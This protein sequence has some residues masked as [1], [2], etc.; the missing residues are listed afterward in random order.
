MASPADP[1]PPVAI[2]GLGGR[3]PGEATDP[4]KLYDMCAAGADAWTEVP[5]SRF[6]HAAF[7]HPDQARNG[8]TNVTGGFYLRDDVAFF[9][10]PFFGITQTEAAS[11][12]P[13]QRLLLECSYEALENAGLAL[14]DVAGSDMGVFVG[15]FC[16]DWAKMTLRDP[17]AIPLYHATGTGQAMLANRLSYF[18]NLHGPSVTLD[19]ACSS[20]LVA[21]HQACQ[22]LRAGECSTALVAGVNCSLCHDSLAS[23]SSM[24]FLSA[25]GRSFTYDSRAAGYG[26]GEG[27]AALVLRRVEAAVAA[28][29]SVRA[30]V[31]N[32]GVN[33]DGRTPGITF[34]SGAAQAALI[35]R[36]YAQAGL[37]LADTS[38]VEAHGTG[39]QAGDPIE[40]RALAETFGAVRK[41]ADG[42]LVVGCIKTNI[43]H[44]EGAS[45]AAGLIKTVLM[46]ER[47]TLLPNC[48]FRE[49]NDKIPLADWHLTV[50]TRV[51]PWR[52]ALGTTTKTPAVL[53]ASIN[54]FGYGGTNAH[55]IVESAAD[56]L[57]AR[58]IDGG[59]YAFSHGRPATRHLP[60][61]IVHEHDRHSTLDVPSVAPSDAPDAPDAPS[62]SPS[63]SP[64]PSS[65]DSD[66]TP[67]TTNGA[68]SPT[69]ET[70]KPDDAAL[71]V[72]QLFVLSAH[73]ATAG[74]AQAAQLSDYLAS[75]A[76]PRLLSDLAYTLSTR[77]SAL[78]WK[79]AVAAASASQLA[80]ALRDS[81]LRFHHT[82]A[83]AP[84]RVGFVFT[85]QGAQ[86][87]A[88]GRELAAT[89]AVFRASLDRSAAI[90][91]SSTM[92]ADW[93]LHDEL[94]R[95]DA[96]TTRVNE[97]AVSQPLCTVLQVA[98]VDLLR[99]WGVAPAAVVGHSSGEIGAAYAAGLLSQEA[100][101]AAAYFRVPLDSAAADACRGGMVALACD[102]ATTRGL[103]AGLRRGTAVIACYNS[104][105]SFTVSGDDAAIEELAAACTAAGVRHRTLVVGFAYHSH[106]MA[107]AAE[108]YRALLQ[109]NETVVGAFADP[110]TTTDSERAVEM[111][112]SVTGRKLQPGA[113]TLDYWVENLV[114]PVRFTEALTALCY[115]AQTEMA[116]DTAAAPPKA[117]VDV[118]VEVGPHAALAGPIRQI[119]QTEAPLSKIGVLSM[120]RR[121]QDATAT[122]QQLACALVERGV[123]VDVAAANA[124]AR[125]EGSASSTASPPSTAL[126]LVDLPPYPWNHSTAYWAEPRDSIRYRQ[127][128]HGRH[129][130]LGAPVRFGSPLEPRWRQWIRTAETPWVRDHRVQGLVVY[131]A[132][133]YISMAIEAVRQVATAQGATAAIASYEL[134]D[135]SLG[136]ALIVP[137][138]RDEVEALVSLRPQTESAMDNSTVWHE[139][140]VYSC[141]SSATTATPMGAPL[142][143]TWAEH[144]R[145]RIAVRWAEEGEKDKDKDN[146]VTDHAAL[147][148]ARARHDAAQRQRTR[149]ACTRDVDLAALYDHCTAIGLEYGP[150]F[151]NLTAARAGAAT[152][153][154]PTHYIAGTV[155]L[156]DVAA[157]MPAHHHS[158]LV[159]HPGTLDACLHGIMAF[160]DLLQAAI[161][162]VFFAHISIDAALERVAAGDALDVYLG[163][164]QSGFRNLDIH[165]TAYGGTDADA[166]LIRMDGLRMTSLAGSM[167]AGGGGGSSG[168]SSGNPPKTY[169]QA[170]W[171]PDP[172]FL[173]S[174]QF[175]DLCAHLMPAEAESAALRRLDQGAFYMADAAVA[176]VPPD[177][178]PALSTKGRKLY[179]SLRR[180][181]DAVLALHDA[182]PS[183]TAKAA[184]VH[185]DDIASWPNAS[186]AER[187]ALLE[188]LAATGA[189]GR[190]LAAVA[191]RMH[192][193][194]L[195]TADPLEV[196]MQ[197]DVLGQYYAHNPRMARQYQQ[198]AVYV[199][200]LA[201]KNPHMRIL[202]IG[203]G[204]GGATLPL[205]H[206][207]GG[208]ADGRNTLPR[209]ASYDVT[210][211]S[212]GFFEAVQAKTQPWA[213]LLRFRRLDIER[214]PVAQGVAA[215]AYDLVVAANV[216]HATRNMARTVRHAR[217][218]L[219]PGGT[220]LLIELVRVPQQRVSTAAVGNIFGI[221][222]GWWVAEEPHRQDSPLLA[223]TQWDAVLKEQGFSGLDAAV[224][225]T[226]DVATH[227]G[228]TMIST[229][230]YQGGGDADGAEG[231]SDVETTT[232]ENTET[233][234]TEAP[235]TTKTTEAPETTKTTTESTN[236]VTETEPNADTPFPD[237]T[238]LLVT[239]DAANKPWLASLAKALAVALPLSPGTDLPVYTL[240]DLPTITDRHVCVVYQTD[241]QTLGP[242][243]PASMDKMRALFLRP[244][245]TSGGRVLWLTRGASDGA[246]APDFALI[247]GLLRTLRVELG[248]RLVHLDLDVDTGSPAADQDPSIQ[249]VARVYAKSF[250][251]ATD[252]ATDGRPAD[253]EL[254]LAVRGRHATV[255]IPRYDEARAPSDYVAA[256]TGRRIAVPASPVQPGRHLQL[257]VGQPG[258]LDSLYFDDDADADADLPDDHVEIAV[259]AAGLNFHDVMVA[260]G[261]I[262]TRALG[263][264]CA[265]VVRRVGR[266]VTAVRVGDRVAAPADGTFATTVRC[267]AWRAQVLPDSLSF[268]AAAAL[269]IVL[270]TALHAVRITQLAAGETVLIH[271]ASGGLGQALVQL[272]QQRGA[273]VYATVGTPAKKQLLVD[274]YGLDPAHIFSSRDDG[275]ADAVRQATGGAGVDVVFNVLAGE[276]LRASWRCVAAFGRFVELGKR[277]LGRN[278]RLDMAPFAR[279]VTFVAVDL[280][281]L[282]AERPRYGAALWA[283]SMD[284]VRQGVARAPAPLTTYAYAD[285]VAALRT[286]QAG[287]HVDLH[288]ANGVPTPPSCRRASPPVRLRADASYLL[289]GGLGGIGRALAARMVHA[290]GARHLI[291]LSRGDVVTDVAAAAVADLRG[292]GGARVHVASNCDVGRDD[293]LAAALAAAQAAGF[294]PVRGVVHL[295]LVMESALFQDMS[296]AAWNHS[297]W[298]KVAGTWNLHRQLPQAPGALDFFVL[299]SS[300]VGT[301]GNP[302]QA[303]YGAASTFQDAFARYRRRRG[304]PATTLDLGM[305]TGIGYVAEHGQVQQTLRSQGFEEISGDECLALVESAMLQGDEDPDHDH[306]HAWS[307]NYVTGLGLGRYAGGD[308]A[309]AIYQDPRFA[310]ARRMALHAADAHADADNV[311]GAGAGD[312]PT[313][314]LREAVRQA[315]SLADVVALLAAALRAKITAL[316]MLAAEDDLDP[317][318]PLSQYGLD[319]LIAVE[320]RNWVSS[321]M[322]ATVP[323]LEFLGS[324]TTQSLSDFIARQSRLV[325]KELLE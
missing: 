307:A 245:G 227:Q 96:A 280:V 38:Y 32:T 262:E 299:L 214:D 131:P 136:Q 238:P 42:P 143:E 171:R 205:L 322:E 69:S 211:I 197:G 213:S 155:V 156:P 148:A 108:A 244:A 261:Q 279:N 264:E 246:S 250:G 46:L 240:D 121:G 194:V 200:L 298:P 203:A 169:F 278:G 252:I 310:M 89:S 80:A 225:E 147:A 144:C 83:Q 111:Y 257:M 30:V 130:L 8:A 289:V 54:G 163:V 286:M 128:A 292:R 60:D 152:P 93:S 232:I 251:R 243:T 175:D 259:R 142:T 202:E 266:A 107:A 256:R 180:Q 174:A 179:A 318:K 74:K 72:P 158:P 26:R 312:T 166:P 140:F 45:G 13:Q 265:G 65:P 106:R 134:R 273:V 236:T 157:V 73:D 29:N 5:A 276:L 70:H 127:R 94:L 77:R 146:N 164:Q 271:A 281:A 173:S 324:R 189:E 125:L 239:D 308:P 61:P 137:E 253:V 184:P 20:S 56:F 290:L 55:V 116:A 190:L 201:H 269:P 207:L 132:A 287:R 235:E 123:A 176:Q 126:P 223:E 303:A 82:P 241:P 33:Q 297:L 141:A 22:A 150:T 258:L 114:S 208:G 64:T 216:L 183:A 301:I 39:T 7:Y 229:A 218:L 182:Q 305:V 168:N 247:Q 170:E 224:W 139:F 101:V 4:L 41:E 67:P 165:L 59:R 206:A 172:A 71:P 110:V 92:Q 117:R 209:F 3:F 161:M 313:R 62:R 97:P 323:V 23:M 115:E 288:L 124:D 195:G 255:H 53:R 192:E 25:A 230:V 100:A 193:I 109:A 36:V 285:A 316:L 234:T 10:A 242:Q 159:V 122:A 268:A 199:D 219:R 212:S 296:S 300:M 284:L 233:E 275:F 79:A 248:G 317:H 35:R 91:A 221:F 260:M 1:V 315:A 277:D 191:A 14:A 21:L 9:D 153:A 319:S 81:S 66:G 231:V 237:D 283:D 47:E 160:R 274:Q 119:L 102:E 263:R 31:R 196:T 120:L 226:P 57:R 84:P 50:P 112:S 34:P 95:R 90:L 151:A 188:T 99:S 135:V 220:L 272:C 267:A 210:D 98:L 2:I 68:V 325:K 186:P 309:R 52:D 17:D 154:D 162:P 78:P 295:G 167:P 6:N 145:G 51:Q 228:T 293:Q 43:G 27:V 15:S 75:A 58:G 113:L 249:T 24:G 222:D 314:S 118:L 103:L 185:A 294:P 306:G 217:R 40:A 49:A 282:L 48:D 321:E 215:G 291:L 198:A 105:Q 320:L 177:A 270:C 311:P 129:D 19:T 37:D 204:T 18:F 181:R 11:L 44:L 104:P 76:D 85:G 133:G 88:M 16:F 28:G 149:D 87:F 138:G 302:S 63:P 304:L 86:W 187:A 254:E 12:D 178:V